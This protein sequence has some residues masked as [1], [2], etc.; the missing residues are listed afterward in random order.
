MPTEESPREADA[1][2][3]ALAATVPRDVP[4]E[5]LAGVR[6]VS[7]PIVMRGYDRAAV[8]AY[9]TRV[10]RIIAELQVSR[11]PQSAIIGLLLLAL[12]LGWR[13]WRPDP[14]SGW[15]AW[16]SRDWAPGSPRICRWLTGDFIT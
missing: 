8:D 9:V 3:R 5:E 13:V 16:L 7:F 1:R 6:D 14:G 15:L 10:N 2:R 4:D 11:S 12:Y